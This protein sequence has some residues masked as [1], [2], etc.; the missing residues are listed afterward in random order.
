M[1]FEERGN[2]TWVRKRATPP[3]GI[4]MSYWFGQIF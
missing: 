2:P 1:G 4:A 3:M